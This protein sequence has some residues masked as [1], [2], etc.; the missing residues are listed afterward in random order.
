MD[1]FLCISYYLGHW[2]VVSENPENLNVQDKKILVQKCFCIYMWGKSSVNTHNSFLKK[3]LK[4]EI[5]NVFA[6]KCGEISSV[7]LWS[8]KYNSFLKKYLK[9]EIIPSHKLV[10]DKYSLAELILY[11]KTYLVH[12]N[13]YNP[14]HYINYS[15]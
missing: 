12:G 4:L 8:S 11:Y 15:P 1:N 14:R 10:L 6:F 3:Y 13:W 5:I 7:T 2:T 9:L